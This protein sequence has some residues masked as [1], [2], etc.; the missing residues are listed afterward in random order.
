MINR[1]SKQGCV[2]NWFVSFLI[3]VVAIFCVSFTMSGCANKQ[4]TEYVNL[5]KV[6]FYSTLSAEQ[7]NA[8]YD[9]IKV[10]VDIKDYKGNIYNV[11]YL[12][13]YCSNIDTDQDDYYVP[14]SIVEIPL[15]DKEYEMIVT[16]DFY[17][18]VVSGTV[19]HEPSF[20]VNK[21]D[22]VDITKRE[23]GYLDVSNKDNS[24]FDS[25]ILEI[26]QNNVRDSFQFIL[27]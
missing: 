10:N 3:L 16:V 8:D 5:S 21:T 17:Q 14:S 7:R 11:W 22:S 26:N 27:M 4:E 2:K 6:Y 13:T 18:N 25:M 19:Y 15:Y 12:N 1:E 20:T 23:D 9:F 24:G